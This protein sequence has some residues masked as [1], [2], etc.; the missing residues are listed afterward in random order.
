[1]NPA[2]Q[3]I[4]G[5]R[6]LDTERR[7]CDSADI[8]I[9][10]D[11]IVEIGAPGIDAPRDAVVVDASDRLVM[12]GLVNAHT[13]GNHSLGKGLGDRWSLELLQ[14]ANAWMGGGFTLEDMYTAGLLNAAQMVLKGCT[15]AYDMYAEFPRPSLDGLSA[16]GR[17]YSEVGVRVVLAPSM[18]DST[19]YEAVPG[20]LDALPPPH[21][22][23]VEKMRATPYEEHIAACS[24]LLRDWPFDRG[25]V[26]PAL[27]PSVPLSCSDTFIRSCTELARD[28]DVGIQ[29]HVGE[30]KFQAVSGMK[31]YGTSL[32]RH[33]DGLGLLG[34]HFTGAHCIWLDDDDIEIM[35][36]RGASVAH[37]PGSNLRL[38]AGI[39]PARQMVDRGLGVGIGTD[40]SSCADSQN[41]FE[42]MRTAAHVSRLVSPDPETWLGSWDVLSLGTDR[43]AQVLGLDAKIGCLQ[44]GYQADMVFLDLTNVNFVPLNDIANQV[45][46]CEDSSAVDSVMIG[47][48]MVLANRRFTTFDYDKLRRDVQSSVDRLRAENAATREQMDAMATF[49]SRHC[50]GLAAEG[51]HVHRRLDPPEATQRGGP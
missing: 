12:P 25:R 34:R 6:V 46:H 13:H 45:V 42:A 5:G 10:G 24:A 14:N 29:M 41:M 22:D 48:R 26:R 18:G 8:V 23:V 36:D 19:L 31:R 51:Y 11:T 33:L 17:A 44:P 27:G 38:G 30:T 15:A 2:Y 7:S 40:G 28:F 3:V 35:R 21:R 50:I 32:V 47:G 37:N 16:V 43:A 9:D 49:V 20:L 1:M 39:A 4:R